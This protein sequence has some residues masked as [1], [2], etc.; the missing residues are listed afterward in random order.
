M[1][2]FGTRGGKYRGGNIPVDS[3]RAVHD[4]EAAVRVLPKTTN[5][6]WAEADDGGTS[7]WG[8]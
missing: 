5:G 4:E 2:L 6:R 3:R 8:A 7:A 1:P